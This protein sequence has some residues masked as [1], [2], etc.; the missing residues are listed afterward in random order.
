MTNDSGKLFPSTRYRHVRI[1]GAWNHCLC[2]YPIIS[3]PFRYFR[4]MNIS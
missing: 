3:L 2:L 4:F 1:P